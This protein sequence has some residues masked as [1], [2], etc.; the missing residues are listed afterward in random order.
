MKNVQD[1]NNFTG[2]LLKL[3]NLWVSGKVGNEE[4][5]R[6]N[7]LPHR[8]RDLY[9]VVC[10]KNVF[11]LFHIF[12]QPVKNFSLRNSSLCQSICCVIQGNYLVNITLSVLQTTREIPTSTETSA[13]KFLWFGSTNSTG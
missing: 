6:N 4:Q 7:C 2:I 12:T 9:P 5:D 11:H 13:V 8:S 10:E 3:K 1:L